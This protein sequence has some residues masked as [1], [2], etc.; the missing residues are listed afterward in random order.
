MYFKYGKSVYILTRILAA[1][2]LLIVLLPLVWIISLSLRYENQIYDSYGYIIPKNPTLENFKRAVNYIEDKL[3]LSFLRMFANS[4]LVTFSAIIIAIFFAVLGGYGFASYKFK[5]KYIIFNAIILSMLIPAQITLIPLYYLFTKLNINKVLSLILIY[6]AV[7]IPIS[8]LI[9]RGFFM[10]LPEELRDASK[11][12]GANDLQHLIKI[13][14]PLSRPAIASCVI[15]LFLQ[16]WNE[17]L[18]ALVFIPTGKWQTLPAAIS[19][20]GGGQYVIPWGIY[21][22]SIVIV[23]IPVIIIFSLFQR[24]FIEGVTL[25]ALKG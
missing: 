9:L 25:G 5:G 14:L 11:I 15:F 1:I 24:W 20:I 6:A 21:S 10:Q 23:S 17:F 22:A 16:T 12:D 13:V 19:K 8:V 2:V 18:Y 3:K 4:A 7:G